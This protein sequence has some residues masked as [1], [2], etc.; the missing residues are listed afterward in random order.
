LGC[1]KGEQ[2]LHRTKQIEAGDLNQRVE[3]PVNLF[4]AFFRACLSIFSNWF[5][6]KILSTKSALKNSKK[7]ICKISTSGQ[8]CGQNG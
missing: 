2:K 3:P 4:K 6:N 1:F 7:K 5:L 8:I